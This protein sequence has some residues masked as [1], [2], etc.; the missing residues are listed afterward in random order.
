MTDKT[1]SNVDRAPQRYDIAV[2]IAIMR[3]WWRP[4]MAAAF[5]C[6]FVIAIGPSASTDRQISDR[7]LVHQA[8]PVDSEFALIEVSSDDIRKYGRPTLSRKNFAALIDAIADQNPRRVMVDLFLGEPSE[9]AADDAT[10]LALARLGPEHVALTTNLDP[11]DL[12]YERFAKHATIL[13]GRL[14]PDDDGWHRSLGSDEQKFGSNPAFWLATGEQTARVAQFDLR[15]AHWQY[16]RY[17]VSDVFEGKVDLTGKN[18]VVSASPD[19]APTRA[20]LPMAG[21]ASRSSVIAIA[22]QSV[23]N[24]YIT[25]ANR[26]RIAN[27]LLQLSAMVLG[28]FVALTATSGKKL[29]LVSAVVAFVLIAVNFSIATELGAPITPTKTLACFLVMIN[30]TLI[31]RLKIVPMVSSFLQGDVS[32]EEAWAWRSCEA[33][34]NPALLFSAHGKIKRSNAAAGELLDTH[35]SNLIHLCLP[36]IGQRSEHATMPEGDGRHFE[37]E[38]PYGEVPIAMLRDHTERESLN[39]D[40]KAQLNTDA[41]TGCANRRGFDTKLAEV[42]GSDVPYAVYFLDLNGFKQINDTLGHDAGDE[43]LAICARR[44]QSTLSAGDTLARLG[45]DEFTIILRATENE[46]AFDL[47]ER[48]LQ[49]AL[50]QPVHLTCVDKMVTLAAAIGFATPQFQRENSSEVLRRADQDMYRVKA[51]MKR[52]QEAA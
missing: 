6:G 1:S 21:S 5:L 24:E 14:T 16:P 45:G 33:S 2:I 51:N 20:F 47:H 28:F 48:R 4:I 44:L 32:P 52:R 23:K 42:S 9:P 7:M 11:D 8:G 40:L 31:Q 17:S 13:D 43:L 19:I 49:D 18:I 22:A 50:S 36:K 26:G 10:E 27:I 3:E 39:R 25:T 35:G 15:T 46:R 30:V 41:L 38:W 29:I 12:P 34:K 37:I